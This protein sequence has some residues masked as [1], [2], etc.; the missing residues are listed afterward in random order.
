MIRLFVLTMTRFI[1]RRHRRRGPPR[2]VLE[3]QAC[4]DLEITHGD[5][6]VSYDQDG[7]PFIGDVPFF[8]RGVPCTEDEVYQLVQERVLELQLQWMLL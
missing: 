2:H 7:G 1:Q 6:T 8:V 3:S 5:V 4:D